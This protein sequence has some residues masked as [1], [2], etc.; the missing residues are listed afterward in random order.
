MALASAA[1]F[2]IASADERLPNFVLINVDDLGYADIGPFGS[3]N[4]TPHLNQMAAE[5]RRLTNH[6]AAPVC[7]PSRAS[8]MT[9][10]YP[11][12]VL[13]ISH[14]LFPAGEVGLN[15]DEV[16]VA[17][18]LKQTGYATACFGKWHLGDQ[19]PFLPTNQGFDTYFGIPY[20]NDMGPPQDGSKSNPGKPLP[21][22]SPQQLANDRN[23]RDELG[24][25][26]RAQPPLP[27]LEDDKVVGRVGAK[28]QAEVTRQYTERATK[29]IRDHQDQPFFVY[30][31]H[32][33]VHF[34]LYP[35]KDF[36]GTSPNGLIGDW[37]QE[38]DW[39]VGEIMNTIR[40]LNLQ[41]E[42]LVIF[43][44]D[45]GGALNHGSN[46]QPLRGSKGQT[47][48]GGIRVCTVAWWPGKIPPGTS[49]D[50]ITSTMDILPTFASLAGTRPPQDCKIDGVDIT[51][52]LFGDPENEPR[53]DFLYFR[54]LNLQA[55]RSGPW[56]LHLSVADPNRNANKRTPSPQLFH[57]GDDIGETNDLSKANP[58][59]VMQLQRLAQSVNE[60]L[61]TN[62][63][64]PGC[65]PLGRFENPEPLIHAD[66]TVRVNAIA[67][68]KSFP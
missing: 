50:A 14:V 13:P 55:V 44:S 24:I 18:L 68:T 43:T 45:N 33:A 40:E 31:P 60:D 54:G 23:N 19:P 41:N 38:V 15:P 25:R 58:E 49:T 56:K 63:I 22:A 11:K 53:Q 35:S 47:W 10:C 1:W 28:E 16:T 27:L 67:N 65:R 57:L 37:A 8:L 9:G 66:G 20:S 29:F 5:G 51:P 21:E 4:R 61:G 48:E 52:V 6:Y 59:M 36:I 2:D 34:P 39:S 32:S 7:S 62:N 64:G 46:N 3:D 42:T 12:R 26:G 30:L 17:E